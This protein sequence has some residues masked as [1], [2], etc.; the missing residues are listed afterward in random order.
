M[1]ASPHHHACPHRPTRADGGESRARLLQAGLRLFALQGFSQTSTRE[2]AEA[3]Q[4][5]VA[6]I[7]YYFG[8]KAGL[9]R[10]AF[11]EHNTPGDDIARF[12]DP[13]LTLDE[14][15]HVFFQGYLEPLREDDRERLCMKLYF[16]E[17]LE[18]T[19][20]WAEAIDQGVLPTHQALLAVLCR[21]FGLEQADDDLQRL[22]ICIA[23]LGVHMH[24][25]YDVIERLAPQL[26][27][28]LDNS[29]V[30]W[31][32][33]LSYMARAMVAAEHQRRAQAERA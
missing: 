32:E 11:L 17:M 22:A 29:T 4:V 15:L 30:L 28:G 7:S 19:G 2:L 1:N 21:D 12:I 10:A 3:A 27:L 26:S 33:R 14:A 9:Y 6:A 5:N 20:L 8:D 18:P 31:A 16:R 13:A 25:G 23:G 24:V